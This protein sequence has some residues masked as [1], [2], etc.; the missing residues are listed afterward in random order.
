MRREAPEI[1]TVYLTV[2]KDSSTTCVGPEGGDVAAIAIPIAAT[3]PGPRG[4][5]AAR[6][7]LVPNLSP[8]GRGPHLVARLPGP[9]RRAP[10]RSP[11]PRLR[12]VVWTVNDPAQIR[13]MLEL[14]IDGIIS[15][16]PDLVLEAMKNNHLHLFSSPLFITNAITTNAA[17]EEDAGEEDREAMVAAVNHQ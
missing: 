11:R 4:L 16:R 14:G 1:A 13:R 15:D 9:R 5:P 2:Q 10:R 17:D 8:A 3:R 7:R 12:V 6:P